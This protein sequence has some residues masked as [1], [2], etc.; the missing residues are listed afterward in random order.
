MSQPRALPVK[1]AY[2]V[3]MHT[4]HHT[5]SN[6]EATVCSHEH[7]AREAD[8]LV[9]HD[10]LEPQLKFLK[11]LAFEHPLGHPARD[12]FHFRQL[13]L[14]VRHEHNRIRSCSVDGDAHRGDTGGA[15]QLVQ[16]RTRP[17][18][19]SPQLFGGVL[20]AARLPTSSVEL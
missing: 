5:R 11:A 13:A 19:D 14:R 3:N 10:F 9:V 7:Y 18:A 8:L 17:R 12:G 6:S 15:M 2:G 1:L 20:R 4:L 16:V